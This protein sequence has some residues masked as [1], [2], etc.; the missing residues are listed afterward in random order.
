MPQSL[1]SPFKSVVDY[2]I[3]HTVAGM[4][5][6]GGVQVALTPA[7]MESIGRLE[8]MGFDRNSC[9]EAFLACDKNEALAA[10]FLLESSTE[11]MM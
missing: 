8:A 7:E 3:G 4:G 1:S 11:D 9:L 10:N 5:Q 2:D 6:G